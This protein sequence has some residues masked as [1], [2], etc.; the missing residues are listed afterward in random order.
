MWKL[1]VFC[2]S[3][4]KTRRQE[5]K[6]ERLRHEDED[7]EPRTLGVNHQLRPECDDSLKRLKR[8]PHRFVSDPNTELIIGVFFIPAVDY[9]K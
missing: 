1:Y 9:L 2:S 3:S 4:Q 8:P 7:E 5:K 6:A